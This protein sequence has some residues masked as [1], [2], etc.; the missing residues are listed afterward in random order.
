VVNEFHVTVQDGT[1]TV[2]HLKI[3]TYMYFQTMNINP[4]QYAALI[5][6]YVF[7]IIIMYRS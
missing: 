4:V 2:E 1:V 3:Y 5:A 6:L 7:I